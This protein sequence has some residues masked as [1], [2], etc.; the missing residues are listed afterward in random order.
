MKT[1]EW[2]YCGKISPLWAGMLTKV[3]N[4][5][6]S[7]TIILRHDEE[8]LWYLSKVFACCWHILGSYHA[9]FQFDYSFA[10]ALRIPF[11]LYI[12]SF[13]LVNWYLG[14]FIVFRRIDFRNACHILIFCS[15]TTYVAVRIQNLPYSSWIPVCNVK[16]IS[17]Y[18]TNTDFCTF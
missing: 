4:V 11:I 3:F 7:H 12:E 1:W 17:L 15:P 2:S 18:S 13:T 14:Y 5:V 6:A 10:Y 8:S 9:V 16:G